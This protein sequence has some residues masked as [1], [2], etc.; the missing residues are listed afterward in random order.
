M[1]I[2]YDT[3]T[4]KGGTDS[5]SHTCSGDDRFLVLWVL[6]IPASTVS[7]VTYDG[8]SMTESAYITFAGGYKFYAF[9]LINPASGSNTASVTGANTAFLVSYNGVSQTGQPEVVETKYDTGVT[10]ISNTITTTSNNSWS[11]AGFTKN[12]GASASFTDVTQ[13]IGSATGL[14][15][16]GD[17]NADI[18][19]A[20]DL[21]QD[22]ST[23][24]SLNWEMIQLAIAP[25]SEPDESNAIF[26]GANF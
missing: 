3:S 7:D 13:R 16:V 1:A 18:T 14:L 10:S 21:T 15:L 5:W 24:S 22:A 6:A 17:N 2:A 11:L 25:V 23:G 19:P 12:G 4:E 20:G 8:V 26:F 9:T